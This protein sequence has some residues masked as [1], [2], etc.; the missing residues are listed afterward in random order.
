V[1]VRRSGSPRWQQLLLNEAVCAG[2]RV[3]VGGRSRAAVLL[4]N[5]TLIRLDERTAISFTQIEKKATSLI[6]MIRG[7]AAFISRTPRSLTIKTPFMNAAIEG[8]EFVVR[9]GPGQGS[10]LVL[11]GRVAV[12]N[13]AGTIQ[14]VD[15]EGAAAGPGGAPHK[16]LVAR[17]RDAVRWALYYPPVIDYRAALAQGPDA[18][19]IGEALDAYRRGDLVAAFTALDRVPQPDRS[20][21]LYALRAGLL[22]HVGQVAGA[23]K[24]LD[25]ALR[26]D[27]GLAIVF[28]L[29]AVIAVVNNRRESALELARRAV[30]LDPGSAVSQIALSY[31]EQGRFAIERAR[32]AARRAVALAPDDPLAWARLSELELSLGSLDAALAAARRAVALN[33][34]LARTQMVL[35][36]AN[37]SRIDIARAREAFEQAIRLDPAAPL[38]HLG[39]GLARI[40]DGALDAGVTE[41]EVA[42]ILDPNNALIRSYLGKGYYEQKRER[43]A[44]TEFA[45]AKRL[46]PRD[47]TPFF[48]D[49]IL[50]QTINRPVEAL[51]DFQRAIALNGNR[52]VFRSRLLLDEDLAAR[53]A[54]IARVYDDL[55][56]QQRALLEGWR[57]VG[58]DPA[59]SAGHRFLADA[60]GALPRHE[61]ARASEL[62]Q[63][64]LL[65]PIN[66]TPVQPQQA[67]T[68]LR[69]LDRA[70]PATTS[71]SEYNPLFARNG[72]ALQAAGVTGSDSTRGD[73]LILSGLANK[74]SV[75]AGQFHFQTQAPHQDSRQTNDLLNG[76]VQFALSPRHNVQ[77]E[78]RYKQIDARNIGQNIDPADE[79]GDVRQDINETSYRGGYRFSPAPGSDLIAS[80]IYTDR[81]DQLRTKTPGPVIPVLT[82]V[83]VAPGVFIP[84]V[85]LTPGT[86]EADFSSKTR[87]WTS[88]LQYLLRRHGF[89]LTAGASY[90]HTDDK[91]QD[92]VRL[93]AQG[94]N[95]P[96][97][98]PRGSRF[99]TKDLG[100][101]VY[102]QVSYPAQLHWTLGMSVDHYDDN[103]AGK[104]GH[105]KLG[106]KLGLNWELTDS[107]VIRAAAFQMLRQPLAVNQT[108]Q[109]TQV[110][111]FNQFFD[112]FSGTEAF[113]YGVGIDHEF[114]ADLLAGVELSFRNLDV[115]AE[116][117][118]ANGDVFFFEDRDERLARA[119]VYLTPT[120]RIA[121]R[122]EFQFEG[123][124]KDPDSPGPEGFKSI[125]T[126]QLPFGISYFHPRGLFASATARYVK[127]DAK[128]FA[129]A[130]RERFGDSFWLADAS[131]GY[132][133]PKRRGIVSLSVRN[134]FDQDFRFQG[135]DVSG[136]PRA[137]L[138]QQDRSVFLNLSLS[139]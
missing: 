63:A 60:Y 20:A 137:P 83:S 41:L 5:D 138:F 109:P 94:Q 80:L 44:A 38:A 6:D 19:A 43:L 37:L 51:H 74:A 52:A 110:A 125:D 131:V 96:S 54:N 119:Y 17:P 67:E 35:G 48:Y 45:I 101:Y 129:G 31:A 32:D 16:R 108:I 56:F 79:P 69:I 26:L 58:L 18:A 55:G 7:A 27:P 120:E 116:G 123:L 14:L 105:T 95:P 42:A 85:Q 4:V 24:D 104:F 30:D 70:G 84:Q 28:A 128:E 89:K 15:G 10:V 78:I 11:Q 68:N 33:P 22:L 82:L 39:L 76:F 126:L 91:I 62:L 102:Y 50:K 57:S 107:T 99:A 103:R 25:R 8:T 132:R 71:F 133:L 86:V 13:P 75:S 59:D 93:V 47:P 40:R 90:Y 2:D 23:E 46:D 9:V 134:L 29:R 61:V 65:Q 106:P 87:A 98:S 113:R 115:P 92:T 122:A 81:D 130:G 72:V 12:S 3:R 36:F 135:T 124:S 77:A 97:A 139:L 100:A 114:S 73:E 136:D 88:E 66:I 64:Q 117:R 49:A 21:G 121:L 1:E 34:R 127:Q 112:D 118:T 111:G 53:T